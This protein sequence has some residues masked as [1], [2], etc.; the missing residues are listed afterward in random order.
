MLEE[1]Y[2]V[3]KEREDQ[4]VGGKE[5]KIVKEKLGDWEERRKEGEDQQTFLREYLGD[6]PVKK[7]RGEI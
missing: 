2:I 4:M 7:I 1:K 6:P 3:W 5:D